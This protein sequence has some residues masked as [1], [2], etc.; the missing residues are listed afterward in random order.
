MVRIGILTYFASINY[1]AFLQAYAL[2]KSLENRYKNI[3]DIELINYDTQTA[4]QNYLNGVSDKKGKARDK[5][6]CQYNK[7]VQA[8]EQ[9]KLSKDSL[10]T[11]DI[12]QFKKFVY[13]RYDIIVV[14]SDEIWKTDSFR[15]FPNAYWL[16]FDLENTVY[17][18]YAVS[19]RNDYQ[20]MALEMQDYIRSSV[21][22]FSYIGTR[23]HVTRNE[24]LKI[25]KRKIY[26]NCDPTFLMPELFHVLN[27]AYIR[28]KNGLSQNKPLISIMIKNAELSARLYKMLRYDNQVICLYN[29]NERLNEGNLVE[30][31][32]FEWSDIIGVSDLV[33]TDYFHGTVF[34]ILHEVPFVAIENAERG[35]GKIENLLLENYLNDKFSYLADYN[36]NYRLA[37]ID[38]F[39][40]G[41]KEMK[42]YDPSIARKTKEREMKKATSFFVELE[43]RIN[44]KIV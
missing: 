5:A 3:V 22:R 4:H 15:G 18:A 40:R 1:G 36:G 37:A 26:R 33:I 42:N 14:G 20:K 35:R 21:K 8:R 11:D 7:F 31:S 10:I 6:L 32:P 25:E 13:G 28:K 30:L 44:D 12:E 38:I 39:T 9:Q 24:L 43:K 16:N 41:R 29:I 27:K 19:G 34:S 23:D 17:M 2:Q